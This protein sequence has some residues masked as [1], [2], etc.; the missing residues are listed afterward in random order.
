[1]G[2]P[3]Y[4][5]GIGRIHKSNNEDWKVGDI[6]SGALDWAEYTLVGKDSTR[7]IQH[8]ENKYNLPATAFVSVLGM[9]SFTAYSYYRPHCK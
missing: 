5:G 6:V 7:N 1:V 9:A 2:K 4:S 8:V 3:L